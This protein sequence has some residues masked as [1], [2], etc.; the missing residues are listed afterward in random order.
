MYLTHSRPNIVYSVG[1]IS[2][3]MHNPTK[4][5]LRVAKRIMRYVAG[6]ISFGI[7]YGKATNFRLY[8]FTDSDWAGCME[9]RKILKVSLLALA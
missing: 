5:H 3:F 7:W 1:V 9:D 8:G 6:T 2:R 4:H